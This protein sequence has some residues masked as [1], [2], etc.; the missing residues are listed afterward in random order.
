MRKLRTL[1]SIYVKISDHATNQRMEILEW[2][3]II[4]SQSPLSCL[5]FRVFPG[6]KPAMNRPW[7]RDVRPCARTRL[8]NA[9]YNPSARC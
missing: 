5:S 7:F 1:E 9:A 2:I 3:I 4:L 6:T 8:R